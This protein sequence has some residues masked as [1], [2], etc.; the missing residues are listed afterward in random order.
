VA[1]KPGYGGSYGNGATSRL[2]AAAARAGG[3]GR[4]RAGRAG[5]GGSRGQPTGVELSL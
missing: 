4:T 2:V 1:S 3:Q 5:S